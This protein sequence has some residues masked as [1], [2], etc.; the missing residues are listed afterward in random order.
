MSA[1]KPPSASNETSMRVQEPWWMLLLMLIPALF[2]T[3]FNNLITL[4]PVRRWLV[5]GLRCALIVFLALALA[6]VFARK[7]TG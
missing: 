4:G 7:P 1:R 3:S 2:W 5:L 6:E